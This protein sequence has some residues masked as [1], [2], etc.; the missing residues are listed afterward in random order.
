MQA[1]PELPTLPVS[2]VW[3]GG[4]VLRAALLALA[5]AALLAASAW[6][7]VPM[8]PVPMTMQTFAVLLIGASMGPRLGAAAVAA[9]LG[10]A[11]LGLPVLAGGTALVFGG[12][13]F[14]YLVG[15][16]LAAVAVGW[17]AQRGWTRRWPGLIGA[18]LVGEA[19][20]F[21]PGLAWLYAAWLHDL[22]A[23]LA[24]GLLPF[25]LGDA[26]KLLLA[27]ASLRLLQRAAA[28]SRG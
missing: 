8:W 16:V 4:G 19:L 23:T 24:A 7:R 13:T 11:A 15:F 27:A 12:P 21:L 2:A 9:Y 14:G 3:P 20:I 18:L 10:G 6:I 28:G 25:L 17:A 1:R 26:L 5:G 22:R